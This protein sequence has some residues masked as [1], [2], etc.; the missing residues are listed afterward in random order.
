MSSDTTYLSKVICDPQEAGTDTVIHSNQYG[1]DSILIIEKTFRN[2][3]VD[4]GPDQTV[5]G[6]DT[7]LLIA[8]TNAMTDSIYWRPPYSPELQR[9]VVV[10][11]NQRFM[12]FIRDSSGCLISDAIDIFVE[13]ESEH[14][15]IY[16]PNIFTPNGDGINDVFRPVTGSSSIQ[17]ESLQIFDRWGNL[18]HESREELEWNGRYNGKML[19]DGVFI[20]LIRYKKGEEQKVET[21]T[22]SLYKSK[23]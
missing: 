22:V 18:I 21:G 6:G 13:E 16:V 14:E 5:E 20:Y 9:Q 4:L 10:Q 8:H 23:P 1:C 15:E 12:I 7:I 17:F 19:N 11:D 3:N 2:I